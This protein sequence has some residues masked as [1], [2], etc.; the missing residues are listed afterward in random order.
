MPRLVVPIMTIRPFCAVAALF[1]AVAMSACDVRVNDKGG[2]SLDVNEGGRAEDTW[3][4]TYTVSKGGRFEL[5]A[6][7]A[8]VELLPATGSTIEVVATRRVIGSSDQAANDL[9][10]KLEMKEEVAPDRVRLQ[11]TLPER[12]GNFR[13]MKLD[14]QVKVPTGLSIVIKSEF[15]N[16]NLN[17]VQGR[18]DV[19][20]TNGRISGQGVSGALQAQAVNGQVIMEMADV[21]DDITITTVNG[22][23]MLGVP[24]NTNATIEASAINGGVI[25][26]ESLPVNAQTKERQRLSG[27]L[28]TGSGPRIELRATNGNVRLGGG[29]PPT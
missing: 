24:P 18:F 19:S 15:G 28:G 21:T 17:K 7:F 8:G 9:L 11:A 3:S 12:R 25:V 1:A 5:D 29:K 10:A 23:L 2:V 16:V 26:F 20:V 4:R 27:R 22:V 13:G 14:Y 6:T